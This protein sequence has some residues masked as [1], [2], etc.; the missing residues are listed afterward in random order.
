MAQFHP[1]PIEVR[2]N[3]F[4]V[5]QK[6][7]LGDAFLTETVQHSVSLLATVSTASH[8]F[9]FVIV[10]SAEPL[11]FR[12]SANGKRQ[13]AFVAGDIVSLEHFRFGFFSENF[14]REEV[15]SVEADGGH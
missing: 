3:Q 15:E 8:R 10:E 11:A 5:E 7:G 2:S 6:M 12:G 1:E 13:P 9:V 14:I 4:K